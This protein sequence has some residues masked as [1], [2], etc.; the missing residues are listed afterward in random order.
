MQ[1]IDR[2]VSILA[3][4]APHT[5]GLSVSELSKSMGL[6]LGT[7]HRFLQSLVEN[8]LVEQDRA[9]KRYRIGFKILRLA[10]NLLSTDRIIDAARIPMR[11][12]ASLVGNVVYLCQEHAGEVI[13]THCEDP[14]TDLHSKF[15][16]QIG[17]EMPFYAAAAAK[18]IFA[19]K[20]HGVLQN[21]FMR[22]APLVRYT[23][24]TKTALDEILADARKNLS[25]GYAV[26]D[27]ELEKG[28]IA[29]AAPVFSYNGEVAGSIGV[30]GI[31]SNFQLEAV[32]EALLTCSKKVSRE[33]G[34]DP[35]LPETAHSGPF[36]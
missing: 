5:E 1:T 20:S 2:A 6:S 36:S 34:Y 19:Y 21:L 32:T 18:I 4:L 3:L 7:T 25:K 35:R 16:D 23:A 9:S 24:R 11:Q 17:N 29:V 8:D 26:C 22:H 15:A 30:T 10:S 13:C 33:L 14:T 27:E 12:A 31:K 28:V